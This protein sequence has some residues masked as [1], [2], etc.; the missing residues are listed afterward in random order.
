MS[1][2]TLSQLKIAVSGGRLVSKMK[3]DKK[4][5]KFQLTRINDTSI[6]RKPG[7]YFIITDSFA[8]SFNLFGVSK[9]PRGFMD[10]VKR[11]NNSVS[12]Q[13]SELAGKLK[14]VSN[15][16]KRDNNISIMYMPFSAL[17]AM[18]EHEGFNGANDAVEMA[19]E[20]RETY[21][22]YGRKQS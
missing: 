21:S 2:L 8:I 15:R 12:G 5:C 22:F 20:L 17:R 1:K 11:L 14:L 10:V 7:A 4:A 6:L 16:I 9:T 13:N 18:L 3:Y 19:R